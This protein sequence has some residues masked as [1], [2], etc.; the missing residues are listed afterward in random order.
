MD[1]VIEAEFESPEK[2]STFAAKNDPAKQSKTP[3]QV[4]S[5]IDDS[6][7]ISR[8]NQCANMRTNNHDLA[9]Q[10]TQLE[11]RVIPL[12]SK[13][14]I[15]KAE[16]EELERQNLELQKEVANLRVDLSNMHIKHDL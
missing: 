10:I 12:K 9:A 2:K 3:T 15:A 14:N 7:T 16:K 13:L 4:T 1:L 5:L 11:A 6:P 8:C